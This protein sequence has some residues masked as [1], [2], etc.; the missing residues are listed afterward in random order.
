MS[1]TR[2]YFRN[3]AQK[4]KE[5]MVPHELYTDGCIYTVML[6]KNVDLYTGL[7]RWFPEMLR[8]I[9]YNTAPAITTAVAS[10]VASTVAT[11]RPVIEVEYDDVNE[12]AWNRLDY[13][14]WLCD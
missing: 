7:K 4:P 9:I 1:K 10:T 11:L 6:P 2:E 14:E 12:E 5:D 8:A 13:Q 3:K